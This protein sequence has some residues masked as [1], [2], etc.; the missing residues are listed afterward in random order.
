MNYYVRYFLALLYVGTAA[1]IS[2]DEFIAS[3]VL[4]HNN[5]KD[6]NILANIDFMTARA[7]HAHQEQ[8]RK[9]ADEIENLRRVQGRKL[10]NM[11]ADSLKTGFLH[12]DVVVL[13]EHKEIVQSIDR[14]LNRKAEALHQQIAELEVRIHEQDNSLRDLFYTKYARLA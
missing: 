11:V 3:V 5:I 7:L 13:N 10:L 8:L 6:H 1:A 9:T 2:H 12:N 4:Q 14:G